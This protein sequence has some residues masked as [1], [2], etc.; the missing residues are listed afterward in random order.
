V[1]I[2]PATRGNQIGCSMTTGLATCVIAILV[3]LRFHFLNEK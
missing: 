2:H 1:D 3:F